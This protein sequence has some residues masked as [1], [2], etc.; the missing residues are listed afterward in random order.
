MR[1]RTIDVTVFSTNGCKDALVRE[2]EG[3]AAYL[4][5]T[6]RD[7]VE[8]RHRC[9]CECNA[10]ESGAPVVTVNGVDLGNPT[11]GALV[12]YLHELV[13]PAQVARSTL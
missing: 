9:I 1:D 8:L 10:P 3:I 7:R 12:D 13:L 4:S 2:L 5:R 6:V 11:I